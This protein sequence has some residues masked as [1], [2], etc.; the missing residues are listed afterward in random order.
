MN[1]I[2]FETWNLLIQSLVSQLIFNHF[3]HFL[4]EL[5][6]MNES[7]LFFLVYSVNLF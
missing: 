4:F 5:L 1:H 6:F 2:L 7:N 3:N